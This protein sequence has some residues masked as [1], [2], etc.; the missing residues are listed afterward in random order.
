MLAFNM[1]NGWNSEV[2]ITAVCNETT[3]HILESVQNMYS[4]STSNS[5]LSAALALFHLERMFND[6]QYNILLLLSQ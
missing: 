4:H 1:E 5:W 3:I 2:A 6:V